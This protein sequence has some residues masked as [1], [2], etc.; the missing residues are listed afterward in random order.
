LAGSYDASGFLFNITLYQTSSSMK[1]SIVIAA[2]LAIILNS[3]SHG[4]SPYEAANGK[5]RCG[6]TYIK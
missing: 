1:R 2:F 4:I 5:A 6:K 3:C